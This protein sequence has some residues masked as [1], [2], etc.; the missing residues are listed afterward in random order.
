[1]YRVVIADDEPV[2]RNGMKNF[3]DWKALGCTVTHLLSDGRAVMDVIK[4]E[5]A[6]VLLID[7]R[8]P[9]MTGLE[10][11]KYIHEKKLPI[12]TVILSGYSYFS[13][14]QQAI[15]Y[16]VSNYI[17]KGTPIE[18][19]E[20]ALG[21]AITAFCAKAEETRRLKNI[22][23][24]F[25]KTQ[26][27]LREKFFVE[28]IN[29]T[30][31]DVQERAEK[32]RLYAPSCTSYRLLLIQLDGTYTYGLKRGGQTIYLSIRGLL[33]ASF[34]AYEHVTVAPALDQFCLILFSEGDE[35][36]DRSLAPI[37]A[38]VAAAVGRY[39][40]S[41][42]CRIGVSRPHTDVLSTDIAYAEARFA[43]LPRLRPGIVFFGGAQ[44]GNS[45]GT[46]QIIRRT[47]RYIQENYQNDLNLAEIARSIGV[48]P[49]YL[50]RSFKKSCGVG[51]TQDIN[52]VR[53]DKAKEIMSM[54]PNTRLSDVAKLVGYADQNYFS[55]NFSKL[56]GRSPSE[57]RLSILENGLC[58]Q[59]GGAARF[60]PE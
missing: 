47:L 22:E 55:S 7:V 42:N 59:N 31:F 49:S 25:T 27:E 30:L 53:I 3:I 50:S 9:E 11:A 35:I 34:E 13:Y 8:M 6:D 33:D 23:S 32:L 41:V 56:T 20:A 38:D 45:P 26:L 1:M 24:A 57:Y 60:A 44:G 51:M 58:G 40:K 17:I 29:G 19:I 10:I 12:L 4:G 18:K 54:H 43:I 37:C 15:E 39:S 5:G 2:I 48:N 52:S 36:S 14:A 16:G 28:L 46:S 21:R